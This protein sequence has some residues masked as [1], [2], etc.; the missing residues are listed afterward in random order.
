M[1]Y[2]EERF[3][4][5]A[6]ITIASAEHHTEADAD[7]LFTRSRGAFEGTGKLDGVAS[8][9][10]LGAA[11]IIVPARTRRWPQELGRVLPSQGRPCE[12]ELAL[13]VWMLRSSVLG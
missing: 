9:G 2:V 10:I 6:H 11:M 5:S 4:S 7:N 13:F 12:Y 8:W 3:G 1:M